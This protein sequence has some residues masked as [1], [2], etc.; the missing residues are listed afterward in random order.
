[1]PCATFRI[2]AP[3]PAMFSLLSGP[4]A[5]AGGLWGQLGLALCPASGLPRGSVGLVGLSTNQWKH[6]RGPRAWWFPPWATQVSCQGSW[7]LVRL[8]GQALFPD[9]SQDSS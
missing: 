4:G 3:T 1:M 6:P 7:R 2:L 8:W 9:H 5:R